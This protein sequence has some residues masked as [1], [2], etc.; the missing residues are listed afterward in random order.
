PE[1]SRNPGVGGRRRVP[2]PCRR[3][4]HRVPDVSFPGDQGP[5]AVVRL[6]LDTCTLIWLLTAE[7]RLPDRVRSAI[8]DQDVLLSAASA[9]EIAIKYGKGSLR[10][11]QPP[12]RLVPSARERYGFQALPIDEESA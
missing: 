1:R 9:W 12:E 7:R 4:S 2:G 3:T 5:A 11:T 10:L 6:L 8:S